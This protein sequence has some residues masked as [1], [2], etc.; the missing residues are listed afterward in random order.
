MESPYWEGRRSEGIVAILE[1]E[2]KETLW[3]LHRIIA[4]DLR[5]DSELTDEILGNIKALCDKLENP[6]RKYWPS[7]AMAQMA[8][9]ILQERKEVINYLIY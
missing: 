7:E 5:N 2:E 9:D 3:K 8:F 4:L 6:G 1:P